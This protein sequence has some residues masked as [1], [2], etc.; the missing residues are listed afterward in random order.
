MSK[1]DPHS[2]EW[3]ERTATRGQGR[4]LRPRRRSRRRLAEREVAVLVGE[5]A[6]RRREEVATLR[7][8]ILR[9]QEEAARSKAELSARNEAQLREA[10]EHLVV[11]TVRAQTMTEAAEQA[12]AADGLYGRAR[13]SHR[14]AEPF[15]AD[16]P[17]G[18]VDRAR[19][20]AWQE[21]RPDV[22]GPRPLQAHQR[23]ARACG[24]R[25]VAAVGR[26]APASLRSPLGYRLPPGGR[27]IRGAA[28]RSRGGAGCSPRRRKVDRGHG[29]AP[30]H[31]WP[32]A[33]RHPEHRHQPLPRRRHRM[34]KR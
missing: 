7:E 14:P 3:R 24:R 16:G 18:A 17:A 1:S 15:P 29:R 6:V 10:N 23:F 31:R 33:P 27:R 4:D 30:S 22:S 28:G 34:S 19:A 11:A 25:P 20:A 12:T 5:Q 9:A 21:G 2:W 8:K 13:L 26:K 32:S